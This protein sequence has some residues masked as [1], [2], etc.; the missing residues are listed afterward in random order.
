MVYNSPLFL[1][2]WSLFAEDQD[3]PGTGQR[4]HATGSV[5]AGFTQE[6]EEYNLADESR[7]YKKIRLGDLKPDHAATIGQTD[8]VLGVVAAKVPAPGP[9]LRRVSSAVGQV[10]IRPGLEDGLTI[11]N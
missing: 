6:F 1:A 4:Y 5:D 9:S 10:S 11:W 8:D 2:H 7:K 3:R